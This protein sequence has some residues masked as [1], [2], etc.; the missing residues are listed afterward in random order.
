MTPSEA[1]AQRKHK[2]VIRIEDLLLSLE[3]APH[4][5]GENKFYLEKMSH[6]LYADES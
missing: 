4:I 5:L 2:H 3:M 6:Q 1:I